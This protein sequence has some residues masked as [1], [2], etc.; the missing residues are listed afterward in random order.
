LQRH[1]YASIE[2]PKE[3]TPEETQR[4]VALATALEPLSDKYGCTTR[5]TDICPFLRLEYFISAGI[6]ISDA[7]RE[8]SKR[9][10]CFDKGTDGMDQPLLY[11]L[12]YS[13]QLN[14]KRNRAGGRINHGIIELLVPIVSSQMMTNRDYSLSTE[15][16]LFNAVDIMKKTSRSDI[17]WLINLKRLAYDLSSDRREVPIHPEAKNVYEYYTLDMAS[18]EKLT[19]VK[20][21]AEFVR[22]ISTCTIYIFI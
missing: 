7:F 20:H 13:A 1:I 11:D 9:I 19:S 8:L 12:G 10:I 5:N 2:W 3:R 18:S 17:E 15:E 6:N 4:H 21:N 14:S 16:V 22:G